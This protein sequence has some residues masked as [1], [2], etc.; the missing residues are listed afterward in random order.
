M[1]IPGGSQQVVVLAIG[2]LARRLGIDP[3]QVAVA[4]V[5]AVDWPDTSLGCPQ[6]DAA[7]AQVVTPG[8]RIQL[9]AQGQTYEYHSDRASRVVPC[10]QP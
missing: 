9:S 4:R 7:Y 10:P 1:R 2:H 5:E 6:P 8:Y 3:G